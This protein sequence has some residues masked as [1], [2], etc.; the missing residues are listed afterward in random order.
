MWEH[1]AACRGSRGE[2][3][4]PPVLGEARDER[5]RREMKAKA[6]CGRCEV[7]RQCLE[8]SL[9]TGERHGIW[10]GLSERERGDMLEVRSA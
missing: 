1:R 5:R 3:F 2:L 8:Y 9:H 6:I 7:Q 10:G 4:Y